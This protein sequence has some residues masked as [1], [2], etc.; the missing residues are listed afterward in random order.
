MANQIPKKFTCDG[1][2]INPELQVQNVPEGA[3]SLA[4]IVRDPD[5]AI[6]GGFVHWAAWNIDP[7]TT[8][9]KEESIPPGAVEGVNGSGRIGYMGPCPSGDRN[10]HY[11]FQLYA[12]DA[13]L[14][15]PEGATMGELLREI[16]DHRL[17]EAEF[18]GLYKRA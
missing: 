7:R 6:S 1:G 16:K 12:L 8:L 3:R 11:H 2:D 15:L 14:N 4:L 5:A 10:H 18:V 9:I 17:E 13:V